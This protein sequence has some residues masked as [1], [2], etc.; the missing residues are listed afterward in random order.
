[1]LSS[2]DWRTLWYDSYYPHLH[3][4][5]FMCLID[6]PQTTHIISASL[7]VI[8]GEKGAGLYSEVNGSK[9]T[10]WGGGVVYDKASNKYHMIAA[11]MEEECGMT[12]WLSNSQIVHA[13]SDTYDGKYERQGVVKGGGLFSHEP[14]IVKALDTNEYVVYYTHNYP[15]ATFKYPC[16]NCKDGTTID[17]PTDGN[18]DYGRNWNVNLPTKMIYTSNISDNNAWSDVID[19]TNVSPAPAIDSNLACYI[20]PNGSLIGILR[21]VQ[22]P[23]HSEIKRRINPL[24]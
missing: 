9:A 3:H 12:V 8:A 17:C 6:K 19:L 13:T 2:M 11:E 1:M 10:T 24:F 4:C 23:F 20:F 22:I 5:T 18:N 16:Y 15:P 14:N 7:N 21:Y